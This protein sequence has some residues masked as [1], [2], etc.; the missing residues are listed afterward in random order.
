M[1]YR[2]FGKPWNA[3]TEGSEH[4]NAPGHE[5]V[6]PQNGM[7][8]QNGRRDFVHPEFIAMLNDAGGPRWSYE[9]RAGLL[10]FV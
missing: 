1:L 6:L 2:L 8:P 7:P 9:S 3:A 5:N 10:T 4:T